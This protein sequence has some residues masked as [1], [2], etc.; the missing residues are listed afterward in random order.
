MSFKRYVVEQLA[1][2]MLNARL[3]ERVQVVDPPYLQAG[4]GTI[5][6][7]GIPGHPDVFGVGRAG[8]G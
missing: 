6:V 5:T 7:R 8:R 4:A 2:M 1:F 3:F